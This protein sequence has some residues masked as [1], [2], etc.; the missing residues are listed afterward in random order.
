[1]QV[2]TYP[3]NSVI[4]ETMKYHA[5]N[6]DRWPVA[7]KETMRFDADCRKAKLVLISVSAILTLDVKSSLRDRQMLLTTSP[8]VKFPCNLKD[9]CSKISIH[10]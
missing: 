2:K 4:L 1:M 7:S 3:G 9:S 5:F 10:H 6:I 8:F